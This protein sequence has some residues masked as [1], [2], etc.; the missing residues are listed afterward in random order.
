M[1]FKK[2]AVAIIGAGPSGCTCAYFAQEENEVTI[3]D[4]ASPL[5]TLLPTGIGRCNLAYAEYD[6]KELAKFYPRGEKFLYSV[7]SQFSTAETLESFKKIGVDTYI[8]DDL[9]IFPT[10]NSSK[11]V[12]EKILNSIKKCKIKREKVLRV[13]NKENGF[14]ITTD[15]KSYNFDKVVIAVGGHA[16]FSLAKNLEHTII[17]P[18]PALVGLIANKSFKSIQGLSLKNIEAQVFFKDKKVSQ[19]QDD[20]LFTHSGISGPLAYKISSLCARLNYNIQSPL[21]IKLNF[22][23][24]HLENKEEERENSRCK[25]AKNSSHLS[26]LT[27]HLESHSPFTFQELLNS[28]P[29]K[30]IKNL[31]S[32][33]VPKSL[34]EYILME[35]EINPNEKCCNIDAKKRDSIVKALCEFEIVITSPAKEGEVVT[36]GGVCLDEINPK[37]MQSKLMKN[38]YFCGEVIDVDGLCGGFNLQNCWSTGY[39]AGTSL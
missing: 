26:P 18:K 27:S 23:T 1:E 35:N 5:H 17:E 4:F 31:I 11:E 28:N 15:Y 30:D 24:P 2:K 8:Q 29:K 10:S 39:I 6:F 16:G 3:F 19:L 36:S 33:F 21:K 37:T 22:I 32:D 13:N 25:E 38:L 14:L 34:A 20:L 7:F 12:R 9:R